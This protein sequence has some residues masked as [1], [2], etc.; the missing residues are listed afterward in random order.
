MNRRAFLAATLAGGAVFAMHGDATPL[1]NHVLPRLYTDGRNDDSAALEALSDGRPAY[2]VREARVIGG[3]ERFEL[4]GRMMYLAR[5]V[6]FS[7]GCRG[8]GLI[9]GCYFSTVPLS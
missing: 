5:P 8:R 9:H 4:R 1:A 7:D 6:T 3:D 2:D